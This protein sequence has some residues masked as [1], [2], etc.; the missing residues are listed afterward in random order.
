MSMEGINGNLST[1]AV[2]QAPARTSSS[3]HLLESLLALPRFNP[4]FRLPFPRPR[5]MSP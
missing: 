4:V 2:Q 1:S 3:P 5:R